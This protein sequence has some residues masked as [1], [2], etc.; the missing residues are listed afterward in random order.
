MKFLVREEKVL[1][2]EREE[3]EGVNPSTSD[4]LRDFSLAGVCSVMVYI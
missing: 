4:A 2:V 1:M 3:E